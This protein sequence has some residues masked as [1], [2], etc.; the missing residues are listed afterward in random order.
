MEE[1]GGG[2]IGLALRPRP[3]V[4]WALELEVRGLGFV[5]L[6]G[7]RPDLAQRPSFGLF[8]HFNP[9]Q[10]IWRVSSQCEGSLEPGH[11]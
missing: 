6:Y 11:R 1:D 7:F 4:T 3:A 10:L 2:G 5:A 9:R 8:H